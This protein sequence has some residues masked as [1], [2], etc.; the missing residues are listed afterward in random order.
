MGDEE[1][2]HPVPPKTLYVHL[3]QEDNVKESEFATKHS[4]FVVVFAG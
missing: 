3:C 2:K 4:H 1:Q